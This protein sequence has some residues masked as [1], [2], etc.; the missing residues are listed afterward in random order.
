MQ[1]GFGCEIESS[2]CFRKSMCLATDILLWFS[3]NVS[4]E[5]LDHHLDSVVSRKNRM[6]LLCAVAAEVLPLDAVSS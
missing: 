5:V 4:D 6:Y 1:R 3:E 2:T